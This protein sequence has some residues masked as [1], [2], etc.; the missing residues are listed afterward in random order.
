MF[1]NLI[2]QYFLACLICK[3]HVSL[4]SIIFIR[5]LIYIPQ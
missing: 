3:I 1:L 5:Y 4:E 2:A